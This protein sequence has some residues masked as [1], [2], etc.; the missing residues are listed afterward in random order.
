MFAQFDATE[1]HPLFH[2]PDKLYVTNKLPDEIDVTFLC[3]G[4]V[5]S[6]DLVGQHEENSWLAEKKK[7]LQII[8]NGKYSIL[9]PL[10]CHIPK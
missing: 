1:G 10:L 7:N 8:Q 9:Q 4:Q 2:P 6:N 5:L 3:P